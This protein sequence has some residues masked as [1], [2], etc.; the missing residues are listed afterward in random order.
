MPI[1]IPY[2]KGKKGGSLSIDR[3]T[4]QRRYTAD[5]STTC[6]QTRRLYESGFVQR[7]SKFLH[8]CQM[9]DF[10]ETKPGKTLTLSYRS[11]ISNG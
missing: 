10:A 3:V 1:E 8:S 2:P 6:L 5:R 7:I 4:L 9:L 11:L